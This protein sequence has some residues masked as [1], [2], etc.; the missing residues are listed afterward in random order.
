MKILIFQTTFR[1]RFL[2]TLYKNLIKILEFCTLWFNL[3]DDSDM[4]QNVKKKNKQKKQQ[5]KIYKNNTHMNNLMISRGSYRQWYIKPF[6]GPFRD[7]PT[8]F[9]D[10]KLIPFQ[11]QVSGQSVQFQMTLD[12]CFF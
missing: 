3:A 10:F 7:F 12:S 5:Q 6:Q 1:M 4:R 9:K 2:F 8:D 11:N